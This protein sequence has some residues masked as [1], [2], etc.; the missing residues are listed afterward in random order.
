MKKYNEALAEYDNAIALDPNFAEAYLGK[1][2]ILYFGGKYG[3]AAESFQKY[4]LLMPGSQEGNSYY[5]KTLFKQG[6]VYGNRR[7]MDKAN[8]KFDEAI[9]ILN[10]VLTIDPN[11][12]TGNLFMAYTYTQKAFIDSSNA[13]KFQNKAIEYFNKVDRKDFEIE[14]LLKLAKLYVVQKKFTEASAEFEKAEKMDSTYVELYREWGKALFRE[15]KYSEA[16][17]KAVKAVELGGD[18][19]YGHFY[20]AICLYADKKYIESVPS[21]K[22][23]IEIDPTFL[24]S[25][26][27]LARAYRFGNNIDEAIKAYEEVLKLDPTHQE[28]IDMIKALNAKKNGN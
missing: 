18:D 19:T 26:E 9:K 11:S 27:F 21:F 1:G 25:R 12:I 14:D 3:D 7:E 17:L 15:Q 13:E 23:S 4:S 24:L 16:Y 2:K 20:I 5:A 8:E 28:A 10:D 6:E 22:K